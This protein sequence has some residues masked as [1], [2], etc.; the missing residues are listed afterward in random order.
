METIDE[1]SRP[2]SSFPRHYCRPSLGW[3]ISSAMVVHSR[4]LG[5]C[6]LWNC[7]LC[8][9]LVDTQAKV[10]GYSPPVSDPTIY[11]SLVSAL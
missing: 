9:T 2:S 3:T 6:W 4:Y 1:G 5:A 11:W 7:K 10:F 8:V